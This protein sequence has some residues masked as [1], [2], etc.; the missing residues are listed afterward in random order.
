MT[1][2]DVEV[3]DV[4]GCEEQ[5]AEGNVVA[6]GILD[7]G[8]DAVTAEAD[9]EVGGQLEMRA[10]RDVVSENR[11][12]DGGVDAAEVRFGFRCVADCVVHGGDYDRVSAQVNHLARFFDHAVGG[13]LVGAH[14]Q[15]NRAGVGVGDG[16]D[17]Q[18]T[19][20]V[21][22]VR[23]FAGGAQDEEAGHT[24]VDQVLGDVLQRRGVDAAVSVAGGD[25]RGD[26]ALEL[27][28]HRILRCL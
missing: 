16:G 1:G 6:R 22:E 12:V 26:D 11:L 7:T 19:F 3:G 23:D 21:A 5:L 14:D 18:L 8:N 13:L 28:G 25:D 15:R 4:L 24:A 2:E 27:S 10:D 20:V 9:Q 17:H